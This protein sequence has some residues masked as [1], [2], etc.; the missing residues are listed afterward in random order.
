MYT[1]GW[2][3]DV[4]DGHGKLVWA[5][6]N[7]Y[8]GVWEDG[9]KVDGVWYEDA[10]RRTF[11]GGFDETNQNAFMYNVSMVHP[12]VQRAIDEGKC[13]FAVTGKKCYFQYLYKVSENDGRTHGLCISCYTVGNNIILCDNLEMPTRE[14][15]QSSQQSYF[16]WREFLL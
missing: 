9:Q 7:T 2:F 4:R 13:T 10:T 1:G 11:H 12:L 3:N 8:E 5:N 15:N 6:G 16:L 14:Q